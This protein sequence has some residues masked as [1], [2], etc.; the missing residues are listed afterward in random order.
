MV[1][2]L[3][4]NNLRCLKIGELTFY[5]LIWQA[6]NGI[7]GLEIVNFFVR[8]KVCKMVIFLIFPEDLGKMFMKFLV[9]KSLD[10][11]TLSNGRGR[12]SIA[13]FIWQKFASKV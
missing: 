9:E 7:F 2:G 12:I 3:T 13:F 5:A 4:N 6:Q 1:I 11:S 8:K 10:F